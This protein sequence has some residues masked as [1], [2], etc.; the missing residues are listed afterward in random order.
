[1]EIHLQDILVRDIPLEIALKN[2]TL[3]VNNA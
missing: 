1:M 2:G 3:V